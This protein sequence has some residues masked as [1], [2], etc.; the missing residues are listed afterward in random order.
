MTKLTKNTDG[1]FN[2]KST[3]QVV[4]KIYGYI[5][6]DYPAHNGWI[7]VGMT[8]RTA[9]E[10]IHE[11]NSQSNVRQE[12]VFETDA[13]LND[14]TVVSDHDLH[15][16]LTQLG[17]E[18]EKLHE[19]DKFSEWFKISLEELEHAVADFKAN[20]LPAGTKDRERIL[21]QLRTEQQDAVDKTTE[22]WSGCQQD[23]NLKNEFLWNAKPRFG[24]TLTSY[25]FMKRIQAKKVLIL[26][27]RPA[28]SDSWFTDY[29]KFIKPNTDYLFVADQA[30]GKPIEIQLNGKKYQTINREQQT[31]LKDENG[32]DY[33]NKPYIF[34]KSLQ[35]IKGKDNDVTKADEFKQ[36]NKWLFDSNLSAWDLL[37]IDESHEGAKT[38]KATAVL[39]DLDYKFKLNLSGT[40]FK[41]IANHE[42]S[43]RQIFNWTYADEQAAKENWNDGDGENPYAKL[44]RMN[45]FTFKL[46]EA[47]QIKAQDAKDESK[48]YAFDLNEF[49]KTKGTG[50]N[51]KF[52]YE[53]EV[54]KWLDNISGLNP[55]FQNVKKPYPFATQEYR[56]QFKHTF[57]L[58][59]PRV[60]CVDALVPLLREH[61]VF[62][63]YKY[64]VIHAA[65][66]GDDELT[67]KSP[68]EQ[69]KKD[70]EDVNSGN[71]EYQGTITLS[72][73]QLT[74]GIT[75]PEWTA[76]LMLNNSEQ[77]TQYL[78]AAFRAQNPWVWTDP[79]THET[80]MK[81]DCY[82]FDFAPDRVLTI[83][84]DYADSLGGGNSGEEGGS[85]REPKVK[86]LLN[87]L[88]VLAEDDEGEM[89]ELD[90]REVLEMPLKMVTAEVV[91]RGFMSN[92]LFDNISRIFGLP[93][94]VTDIL[95]KLPDDNTR[96]APGKVS[97]K[98]DGDALKQ[99]PVTK[100]AELTADEVNDRLYKVIN[101]TNGL[102]G[103]KK[104]A[105]EG[106]DAAE[107]KGAG[108]Q[109]ADGCVVISVDDAKEQIKI[110][111][112]K[113]KEEK[114]KNEE[115]I[116]R[117]KLRGFARTIPTFLM[118]YGATS[119]ITNLS[120]K[121]FDTDIPEDEFE[122]ITSIT[123]EDFHKLRDG[124]DYT[125]G[126][127]QRRFDGLF[128]EEVFNASIREFMETKQRLANYYRDDSSEDIFDYIPPQKTNQI[129]T[130]KRVVKMMVDTLQ[131]E[132]PEL[133]TS[134]DTTFIDLYMKSGLFIAEVAR[135]LFI[136]LAE[137]IPDENQRIKHILEEQVYGIA[138]TPILDAICRELIFGF[139]KVDS[140]ED[141]WTGGAISQDNF[142]EVDLTEAAK[143]GRVR[144]VLYEKFGPVGSEMDD[145]LCHPELVSG[146]NER[147]EQMIKF[148]VVIGNPPYQE[149]AVG[150]K[151][152]RSVY[153]EFAKEGINLSGHFTQL[154]M[155][156]RWLGGETGPYNELKG[157]P[158]YM[159]SGNHIEVFHDFPNSS[160]VFDNVDIKGGVCYFIYDKQHDGKTKYTLHEF[161]Q[162]TTVTRSFD[163]VVTDEMIIRFPQ[164]DSVVRK[165]N[166]KEPVCSMR[167][168]VSSWNPFGFISDLFTKNNEG[169]RL[170]EQPQNDD[171]YL[172]YGLYKSKRT[173]RYIAN[174]ALKKNVEGAQKYKVFLPRANGS[175]AFGEVFSS[176]MLGSPMQI[177]TDTFLQV[178]EFDTIE[179]AEALLKY[180]KT[181][182]FRAMVG[183]KKIAVFNYKDAF[184]FVPL[185]DFTTASDIDW[186][187][188]GEN[189]KTYPLSPEQLQIVRDDTQG[190][191]AN[192]RFIDQQLYNKYGLSQE[193]INF[194]ETRV[195]PMGDG[196]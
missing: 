190:G 44:P 153:Q 51:A 14:G 47:L 41:A 80:H 183:V 127:E 145:T 36:K 159:K 92:H 164:L 179:P 132:H 150:N 184:M 93:T 191:S 167:T 193:E 82:V 135:R 128:N 59:P 54:K 4:S 98:V 119:D 169:V 11:Q 9:E 101:T 130:P 124:F 122:E 30:N 34:F 152:S 96:H 20:V 137:Q 39:R 115:E 154:V 19:S 143:Q 163:N 149:D 118:A 125:E 139:T 146:P 6:P 111:L 110:E 28:I 68:L 185:Q 172:I 49:F 91:A 37:I 151:M 84:A 176:P 21:Y 97:K 195:K 65:G 62:S 31:H 46:S 121:N 180:I 75:V 56:N 53:S 166:F 134:K 48:E 142:R 79:T 23:S 17:Y 89:K 136:G 103:E 22:Y 52:V 64:K 194:I 138:P 192:I 35:D 2:I 60:A 178:G 38:A 33:I 188:T 58:L 26:T 43:N 27:N 108:E 141:A 112:Q 173:V 69:V 187:W 104:Y 162:Q 100:K 5:H 57:W 13:L 144:D 72:C 88:N 99:D 71:S 171:D 67:E 156:A 123:K 94:S 7:K 148:D 170:S 95:D 90:A 70:I 157:F 1:Y 73:G 174:E 55:E 107:G 133:F 42:F 155:P 120:L 87:F 140:G 114:R 66:K 106:S 113:Q 168:L 147:N 15:N 182:F 117:D 196:K 105:V 3:R 186:N 10:R 81:T 116:V 177:C 8:I 50:K 63:N 129:F 24:K 85:G 181:K 29:C 32:E 126:G 61:P 165:I 76:V 25:D 77:P 45:F 16:Y 189:A 160:D 131:E 161:G 102:L 18:R 175:G 109:T 40:P 12:L 78:Q 74:T 83:L 158:Q 86:E